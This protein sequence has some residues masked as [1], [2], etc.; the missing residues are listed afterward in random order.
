MG[1]AAYGMCD[2]PGSGI[3]P[4]S[5]ALAGRFFFFFNIYLFI[6]LHR[7]SVAARGIFVAFSKISRCGSWTPVVAQRLAAPQR[8]GYFLFF[9]GHVM[10]HV[11]LP[12]PGIEPKSPASEAQCLNHWTT[13]EVPG[14]VL[15]SGPPEKSGVSFLFGDFKLLG[16][17]P[18][19]TAFPQMDYSWPI[20]SVLGAQEPNAHIWELLM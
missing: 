13:K 6:Q 18:S 7:V 10:G 12:R 15:T 17:E 20:I 1:L 4:V 8:V 9:F 5:I 16:D 11:E 19:P 3:E 2:L 14:R